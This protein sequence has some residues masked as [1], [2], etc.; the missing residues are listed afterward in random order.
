M[1]RLLSSAGQPPTKRYLCGL[2]AMLL[3]FCG[4]AAGRKNKSKS[5]ELGSEL[6]KAPAA[7]KD[8]ENPYAGQPDAVLAG[9][10]LFERHCASCHGLDGRGQEQAPNLHMPVIQS[11][12]P[13]VL[14]W[15]LRNGSLRKGMP[16]RARLPDQQ[17]WQLVSYLKTFAP[18]AET[19]EQEESESPSPP[20]TLPSRP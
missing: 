15:F 13:G 5:E 3:L 6:A 1:R 2:L 7:A 20:P 12:P 10:K 18:G 14:L 4:V 8:R 17:R 11:A 19:A 9:K 16:S